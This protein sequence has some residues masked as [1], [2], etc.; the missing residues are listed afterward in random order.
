MA[1]DGGAHRAARWVKHGH[2]VGPRGSVTRSPTYRSYRSM[3]ARC[4]YEYMGEFY[5]GIEVCQRW[6]ESFEAFLADMGERPDGTT[7][8]RIK[9]DGDYEPG[10]CRWATKAEQA[11]NR[12]SGRLT[13]DLASEVLGRV[14]HG[15]S[16]KS[17]AS[18]LGISY[19]TAWDV[20]RGRSWPQLV[21]S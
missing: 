7:L 6:R 5:V 3:L 10:N 12:R 11:Q 14:E 1:Q 8:D 17:V 20:K 13:I 21:R 19:H 4:T 15:E 9:N 16:L 2:T 18:R